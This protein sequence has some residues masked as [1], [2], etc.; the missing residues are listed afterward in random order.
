MVNGTAVPLKRHLVAM[1]LFRQR[2]PPLLQAVYVS[3][4]E[5]FQ[6]SNQDFTMLFNRL[7]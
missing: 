3:L 6:F 5:G 4:P 2:L 1:L 7:R